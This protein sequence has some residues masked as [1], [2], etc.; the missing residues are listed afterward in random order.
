[1]N[2]KEFKFDSRF[3]DT[4]L[5]LFKDLIGKSIS[6]FQLE[7]ASILLPPHFQVENIGTCSIQ[8]SY[9]GYYTTLEL[10][11]LFQETPPV[12]D[13]G[14][15]SIRK[16]Y[17]SKI[18]TKTRINLGLKYKSS[19]QT[20]FLYPER[21][22]IKAL[23]FYGSKENRLLNESDMELNFLNQ[24]GYYSYPKIDI[25]TIEFLIIEH[26]NNKKTIITVQSGGFIYQFLT[27]APIDE[28]LISSSYIKVN[29]YEKPIVLQ[30]VVD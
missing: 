12:I 27:D 22:P 19:G 14:G 1:M 2:Q 29:S 16:F 5:S 24:L 3:S 18:A 17:E 30:H 23:K 10:T 15:I 11:S 7:N 21:S 4:E 13:S 28:K 25:N 9:A 26:E 8:F 20:S 6:K